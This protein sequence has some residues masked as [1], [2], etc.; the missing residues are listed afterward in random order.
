[1][2][3]GPFRTG[4]P[5]PVNATLLTGSL[6]FDGK[7]TV[8]TFTGTT[9]QVT[10]ALSGGSRLRTT[11]GWV[12]FAAASL[13]TNNDLRDRDMRR[14]LE[15]ERYPTIRLDIDGVDLPGDPAYTDARD[16]LIGFVTGRLTIHGVTRAVR[17]PID[18]ASQGDTLHVRSGFD[19]DLQEYRIGGL[20][21]MF[22]LLKMQ[23]L[24]KV[25]AN[26]LFLANESLSLRSTP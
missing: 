15:A 9:T 8:G 7:A 12:E 23:P 2:T 1:M 4:R 19:I 26:L 10:G 17:L 16:S 22:G 25:H 18:I 20:T 14:S 11:R 21:K 5:A 6:S 3:L 24:I 13:R